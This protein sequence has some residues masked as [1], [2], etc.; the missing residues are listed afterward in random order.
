VN[1]HRHWWWVLGGVALWLALLLGKR[2]AAPGPAA[3]PPVPT[4]AP[5]ARTAERTA[6]RSTEPRVALVPPTALEDAAEGHNGP[7]TRRGSLIADVQVD[8][9]QVC[10]GEDLEVRMIA[11]AGARFVDFNIDGRFGNPLILRPSTAGTQRY[12]VVATDHAAQRDYRPFEIAVL[13]ADAPAC[14]NRPSAELTLSQ[15]A[16]QSV[17]ARVTTSRLRGPLRY[18]WDFGDGSSEQADRPHAEHSY[19]ERTQEAP[20]SSFVIRVQVTDARGEQASAR[21]SV[22][23]NNPYYLARASSGNRVLPASTALGPR[24][25]ERDYV[26]DATVRNIETLPVRFQRATLELQHCADRSRVAIRELDAGAWQALRNIAPSTTATA[27]LVIPA[28]WVPDEVCTA[29]LRLVGDTEPP[30]TQSPMEPGGGIAY[31]AVNSLLVFQLRPPR[32]IDI[33]ARPVPAPAPRVD[34]TYMAKVRKASAL[35]GTPR[36]T[37]DQ[38][39]KL[40]LE[41]KL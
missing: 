1:R 6:P 31:Q 4:R 11:T 7:V 41:G 36:V 16:D 9:T 17:L 28:A 23:F 33:A 13:P 22:F 2:A 29:T 27:S 32:T 3:S 40:E 21:A 20:L 8:K 12:H 25:D 5:S 39:A 24:Q 34:A 15:H 35:L 18:A 10:M 30:L 19:A 26:F 38:V 37:P 14:A